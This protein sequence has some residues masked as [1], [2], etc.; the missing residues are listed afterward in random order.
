MYI[1]DLPAV[2]KL[3]M[4]ISFAGDTNLFCASHNF[5]SLIE[6]ST[7]TEKFNRELVSVYAWVQSIKHSLNID[8][9]IYMLFSPKCDC[10]AATNFVIDGQR[11]ME[12]NN[13]DTKFLEVIIDKK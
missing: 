4:A 1:N 8:K 6:K 5:N 2:S 13:N 11:K 10:R 12:V 9:T 3:F 7:L